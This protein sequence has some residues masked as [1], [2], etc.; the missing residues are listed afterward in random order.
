MNDIVGLAVLVVV[1]IAGSA[2][3]SGIEAAVLTV[4]PAR[5]HELAN[6]PH[7]VR[8]ARRLAQLRQR[9]GRTLAV[10][11]IANNGFNIFG[12]LM[13]GGLAAVVFHRHD[14]PEV[15]LPLFSVGLTVLVILLGEILPKSMGS[16]FAMPVALASAPALHLL[17]QLNLPLVLILE[18]LL[19]AITAENE[20]ST[21]E[22]EIRL[23]AK[24]GSQKGQIEADEAAMIAKVFQLNDLTAR[25]LMV[26]RV[27]APSLSGNATLEQLRSELLANNSEWWV[28]LGEEVDEVLSVA[29]REALLTALLKGNDHLTAAA[30]GEPVEFV[31]E[32]I[33]ADRLLTGFRRNSTGVRVVVDEF[34]GFVGV[35]GAEA[36]LAVLAG[37]WR[38]PQFAGEG[39]GP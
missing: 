35:I 13:L 24:L 9:L 5:V 11:V 29:S 6:R 34:G 14:F 21:D 7:P 15:A 19:P 38:R 39:Q 18:R 32:M 27:A 3:A 16:R 17:S 12:S 28:V 22:D 36:V 23:L 10:L 37:W 1:V 4:N 33:R 8:G 2:L 20:I 30:L 25:D 31:P 26:P